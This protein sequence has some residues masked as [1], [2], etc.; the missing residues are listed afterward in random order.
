L[1]Y[2]S[3]TGSNQHVC[4]PSSILGFLNFTYLIIVWILRLLRCQT[5]TWFGAVQLCSGSENVHPQCGDWVEYP[6]SSLLQS[7][8]T[9]L[10]SLVFIVTAAWL[11][12]S[13]LNILI[14]TLPLLVPMLGNQKKT[15]LIKR[16]ICRLVILLSKCR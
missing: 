1:G 14:Y 13:R 12:V 5:C 4:S 16:I 11:M 3:C 8:V 15:M 9:S 2:L 7:L 10:F 6:S